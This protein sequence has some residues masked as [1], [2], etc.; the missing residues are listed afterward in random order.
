MLLLVALVVGAAVLSG[1]VVQ[2]YGGRYYGPR[3]GYHHRYR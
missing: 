2:P 1:C 3:H